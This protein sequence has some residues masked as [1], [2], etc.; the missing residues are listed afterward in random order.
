MAAL[1]PEI[2]AGTEVT[3]YHHGVEDDNVF[4]PAAV[5][6]GLVAVPAFASSGGAGIKP[7]IN[8]VPPIYVLPGGN[9]LFE[10]LVAALLI[11]AFRPSM[12]SR[13]RD[14]V[15]WRRDALV[16]RSKEVTEVGYLHSLTFPARRMRL[17]PVKVNTICTRS[18][19][20]TEWGVR[21]MIFEMGESRP[22]DAPWWQDPFAA[23]RLPVEKKTSRTAKTGTAKKKDQPTPIRPQQGKAAWREF[24]GL[25]IQ[26]ATEARR[27]HRPLFIEQMAAA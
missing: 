21:T 27:T 24:G 20:F 15:W 8:G 19:R 5:A 7:S 14:D 6:A 18:G 3:H 22:K 2:P 10:S 11:P 16:E 9:S 12:A 4:S 25:F 13:K 26:Q 1:F 17:H 23:Y